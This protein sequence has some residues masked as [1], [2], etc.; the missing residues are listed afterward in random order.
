MNKCSRDVFLAAVG[1]MLSRQLS[2]HA[3]PAYTLVDLGALMPGAGVSMATGINDAGQVILNGHNGTSSSAWV[4]SASGGLVSLTNPNG[5]DYFATAVNQ[6][7]LVA[8]YVGA[9]SSQRAVRWT[10]ADQFDLLS[11][12]YT[13]ANTID[14]YGRVLGQSGS[15]AFRWD[16]ATGAF[17]NLSALSGDTQSIAHAVSAAGLI[18]GQSVG[19]AATAVSWIVAPS[20]VTSSLGG[21]DSAAFG[22]NSVGTIVGQ[23]RGNDGGYNAVI[24]DGAG[25]LTSLGRLPGGSYS[26]ARAINDATV[27]V[28][29]ADDLFG[30]QATVWSAGSGLVKLNNLLDGSGVGAQIVDVTA[31]NSSGQMVGQALL[32][33]GELHAV[34]LNPREVAYQTLRD[35]GSLD[36]Q[37]WASEFLGI[38]VDGAALYGHLYAAVVDP[39]QRKGIDFIR[40]SYD[41]KDQSAPG[42]LLYSLIAPLLFQDSTWYYAPSSAVFAPYQGE[43]VS[44]DSNGPLS[45]ASFIAIS[46]AGPAHPDFQRGQTDSVWLSGD[47]HG[48][49][50]P[51]DRVGG[52]VGR[53]QLA[54]DH[55]RA[56]PIR[57]G[58]R[59]GTRPRDMHFATLEKTLNLRSLRHDAP[60]TRYR[61]RGVLCLPALR[62]GRVSR[63]GRRGVAAGNPRRLGP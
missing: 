53:A 43:W 33:N 11:T 60:Q 61:C 18:V 55:R 63:A 40:F 20:P 35:T 29:V 12:Q 24:F 19:S 45:A 39:S 38:D 62:S 16:P 32:P 34:L 30:E 10:T 31:V 21:I 49:R 14:S 15:F 5:G 13:Y 26:T 6:N 23:S 1:L 42:S 9:G 58:R 46:G 37:Q 47:D 8:G 56:K 57:A 25:G 54:G 51:G 27:V 3:D 44:T 7:G 41:I 17:E 36:P 59:A 52:C 22:V 28:G 50:R 4:W 48:F 2:V